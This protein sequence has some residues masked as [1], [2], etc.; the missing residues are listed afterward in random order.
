MARGMPT[1]HPTGGLRLTDSELIPFDYAGE[2]VGLGITKLTVEERS[3]F[4]VQGD[5]QYAQQLNSRPYMQLCGEASQHI[6][7]QILKLES[8]TLLIKIL[9]LEPSKCWI[10]W[11]MVEEGK[12]QKRAVGLHP[13]GKAAD[14]SIWMFFNWAWVQQF[15]VNLLSFFET[16]GSDPEQSMWSPR[17]E[18]EVERCTV[19]RQHG[20]VYRNQ[21]GTGPGNGMPYNPYSVPGGAGGD[22]GDGGE[23][24]GDAAGNTAGGNPGAGDDG[25][26]SPA[27]APPAA[28]ATTEATGATPGNGFV[29]EGPPEPE[30]ATNYN[31]Y[32]THPNNG[33]PSNP[34]NWGGPP[35]YG[36][37][38]GG[39]QGNGSYNP[40]GWYSG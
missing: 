5:Q 9:T 23:G 11:L 7:V 30:T 36:Q 26:A 15:N 40:H 22:A 38:P 35:A 27:A 24:E 14:K 25:E 1:V 32:T 6:Y 17:M 21:H 33:Y 4:A 31:P 8:S 20:Q 19:A 3:D 37:N 10:P 39:F 2:E 18:R 16:I 12:R 28:G 34:P 13:Y 29:Y